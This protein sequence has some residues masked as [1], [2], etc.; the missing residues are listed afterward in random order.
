MYGGA[1]LCGVGA[2]FSVFSLL[3]M[4]ASFIPI[5]IINIISYS[6]G[7]S[8]SYLINR[9]FSFRSHTHKLSMLRFY[10]VSLCGMVVSTV[11]LIILKSSLHSLP[12]SKVSATIVA[13]LSQYLLNSK[14]SLVQKG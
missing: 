4:L 6:I 8:A 2:D 3:A 10:L 1:G 7:T 12:V 11:L 9:R 14:Y 13:V 5:S